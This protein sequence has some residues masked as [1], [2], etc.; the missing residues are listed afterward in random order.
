MIEVARLLR[1]ESD[2]HR[3]ADARLI[4]G[5]GTPG[6]DARRLQERDRLIH[7]AME[8]RAFRQSLHRK[9]G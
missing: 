6:D 2:L 3:L 8:V 7:L 9:D 5:Y 1:I 4:E